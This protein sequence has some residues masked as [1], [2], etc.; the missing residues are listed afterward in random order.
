VLV[1]LVAFGGQ[2][3]GMNGAVVALGTFRWHRRGVRRWGALVPGGRCR[4]H[5]HRGPS[6][7][8]TVG[9][10]HLVGFPTI[11]RSTFTRRGR[12]RVLW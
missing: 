9:A 3:S 2:G 12:A 4:D 8:T 1:G 6:M 7:L 10:E 11:G 5:L